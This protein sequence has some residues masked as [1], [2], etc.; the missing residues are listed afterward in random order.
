[1]P[2]TAVTTPPTCTAPAA[3]ER[4]ATITCTQFSE[5]LERRLS[6]IV[7]QPI[8]EVLQV[9]TLTSLARAYL[10]LVD[11]K[12]RGLEWLQALEPGQACESLFC[13]DQILSHSAAFNIVVK[14]HRICS[15]NDLSIDSIKVDNIIYQG[16]K[17]ENVLK[18]L[19]LIQFQPI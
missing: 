7:R 5:Y 2:E 18:N 14:F 10:E 1:M 17:I 16:K 6:K 3:E 15:Q 4:I 12:V 13:F 9:T 19:A 8:E 11:E